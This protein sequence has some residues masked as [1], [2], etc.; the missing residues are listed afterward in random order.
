MTRDLALAERPSRRFILQLGVAAVS[1]FALPT[2][3]RAQGGEVR[4]GFQKGS[5]NLLVL[6]AKGLLDER[7]GDL[8]YTIT[9][10]EFPAGVVLLE[11]LN[12]GSIDF[13]TTGAPPP[14]FAQAAGADLIYV[15]ATTP[16]PLEEGILVPQESSIQTIADLKG[17]KVAVAKGSSANAFLAM[18][19]ESAGLQ[20]GD[21]EATFLL[22]ADAKAAFDGGAID[23]WA[24]WD[25]YAAVAEATS[26][27]RSIANGE[28]ARHTN[29][30]YYLASR[31]FATDRAEVLQSILDTLDESDAWAAKH[32][33]EVARMVAAETGIDE[34]TLLKVEKRSVYGIEP[35]TPAIIE[36]QQALADMFLELGLLP[37]R[38]DIASATLPA[39]ITA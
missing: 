26:G 25:P 21:V 24:I 22:P 39:L 37:E 4:I 17:K 20:W 14:I 29:R 10:T 6:K 35:V 38:V 16:S 13:G 7:L 2:L 27:A 15:S 5:A 11:A 1:A 3:A 9:W 33:E 19:L 8:G 34:A 31:P 28:T 18:A 23:A 32:P 36:E 12:A 30:G